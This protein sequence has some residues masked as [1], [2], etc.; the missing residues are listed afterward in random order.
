MN[1]VFP[2][3]GFDVE[4]GAVARRIAAGPSSAFAAAKQLFNEAM[5]VDRLDH[6]LDRELEALV[7]SA[8]SAEFAE[9]MDAFFA[10]RTPRFPGME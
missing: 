9:G 7:R 5:G 8:D 4:V 10:K 6:H 3:S 1:G 2:V